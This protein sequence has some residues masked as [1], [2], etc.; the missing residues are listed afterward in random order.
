MFGALA[1]WTRVMMLV[2]VVVVGGGESGAAV[3]SLFG[4]LRMGHRRSW[5]ACSGRCS[6]S[7][8]RLGSRRMIVERLGCIEPPETKKN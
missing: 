6:S 2:V 4:V 5:R 1:S 8:V 3:S 7:W